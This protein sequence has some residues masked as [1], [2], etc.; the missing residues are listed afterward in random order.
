MRD[1]LALTEQFDRSRGVSEDD[2]AGTSSR[3]GERS[4]LSSRSWIE[5]FVGLGLVLA[6]AVLFYSMAIPALVGPWYCRAFLGAVAGAGTFFGM[7]LLVTGRVRQP[8]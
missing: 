2:R 3:S 8:R 6:S 1:S 5:R 7:P 4:P